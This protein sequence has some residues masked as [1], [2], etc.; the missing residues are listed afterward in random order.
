M[1]DVLA[2][3]NRVVIFKNGSKIG[4]CLT[5]NLNAQALSYMVAT[6]D[7]GYRNLIGRDADE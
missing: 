4:E 2:V 3:A 5:E 1:E 6:G 7:L